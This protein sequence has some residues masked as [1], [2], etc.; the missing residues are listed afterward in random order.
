M[1]MAQNMY[2]ST[3]KKDADMDGG[4]VVH[5]LYGDYKDTTELYNKY[6]QILVLQGYH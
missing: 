5:V 4:F 6:I 1:G 3:S 2:G